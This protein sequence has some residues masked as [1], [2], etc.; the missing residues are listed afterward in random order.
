MHATLRPLLTI[1]LCLLFAAA[2]S[3][4]RLERR[5]LTAKSY[6]GIAG[7]AVPGVRPDRVRRPDHG[8][9]GDGLLKES[10]LVGAIVIYRQEVRPFTDKQIELVQQ[11]RRPGR[12]RYREHPPAQRAARIAAAADRHRRRAQG[13]QPLDLRSA[14]GARYAGRIG[15]TALRCGYGSRSFV[16]KGDVYDIWQSMAFSASSTNSVE[17]I[18]SRRDGE[19]SPG[20]PSLEGKHRS[21]PGCSGRSRNT[22]SFEAPE[23]GG[24]RTDAGVP[25]LREGNADRGVRVDAFRRCGHSPTSNR[26]GRPPS[27]TRR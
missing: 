24:F 21:C 22:P 11:L 2:A 16:T 17:R 23:I 9:D 19:R 1:A 4:E 5:L 8:A 18:R 26:A 12:H 10:E 25:L 27:P 6:S 3:A 13:H 15:G 7:Q 20:E 14:D